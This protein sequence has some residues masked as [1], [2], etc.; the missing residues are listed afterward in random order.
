[1]QGL[2]LLHSF[3]DF[4]PG[5]S[6][7]QETYSSRFSVTSDDHY[8]FN[9]FF[10][11][12]YSS[13]GG[14]IYYSCS[15]NRILIEESTFYYCNCTGYGGAVYIASSNSFVLHKSCGKNCRVSSDSHFIDSTS[16]NTHRYIY[17]SVDNCP[18]DYCGTHF[19]FRIANGIQVISNLNSSDNK[20]PYHAG[21]GFYPSDI[22]NISLSTIVNN[23]PTGYITVSF[24]L[25]ASSKPI[26]EN[27]NF[28]GN[29]GGG[30][31]VIYASGTGPVSFK[32]CVFSNNMNSLFYG[33]VLVTDSLIFHSE[34]VG[35]VYPTVLQVPETIQIEHYGNIIC[36]AD[37]LIGKNERVTNRF[38]RFSRAI[39]ILNLYIFIV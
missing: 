1:M 10:M 30:L 27:T 25:S 21:G 24:Y 7:S 19:S 29:K 26:I 6:A 11:T 22:S 28:V 18:N 31:G 14:A 36:H 33:S 35:T 5:Y 34:A 38:Q 23:K 32:M 13:N 20:V 3:S 12:S 17:V 4:F 15:S 9:S 8:I 2:V 39:T 37:I 16:S